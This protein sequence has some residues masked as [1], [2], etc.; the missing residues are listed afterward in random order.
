MN[1]IQVEAFSYLER[2]INKTDSKQGN[3]QIDIQYPYS[4]EEINQGKNPFWRYVYDDQGQAV[5]QQGKSKE[6]LS[7]T[8]S[9]IKDEEDYVY[10][11][12][13]SNP[14][15][16]DSSY[17]KKALPFLNKPNYKYFTK[18]SSLSEFEKF[19]S[20]QVNL[21]LAKYEYQCKTLTFPLKTQNGKTSIDHLAFNMSEDDE[22]T[23]VTITYTTS[24]EVETVKSDY[25]SLIKR[26][27]T[28]AYNYIFDQNDILQSLEYNYVFDYQENKKGTDIILNSNRDDKTYIYTFSY[29]ESVDCFTIGD[30]DK[31]Q[32]EKPNWYNPVLIN[33][34]EFFYASNN[35]SSG[36]DLTDIQDPYF[37]LDKDSY[38]LKIYKDKDYQQEVR[39]GEVISLTSPLYGKVEPKTGYAIIY[40]FYQFSFGHTYDEYASYYLE[41]DNPS[42]YDWDIKL[43]ATQENYTHHPLTFEGYDFQLKDIDQNKN[44]SSIN[45]EEGKTYIYHYE[46]E[47][48]FFDVAVKD[49]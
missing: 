44:I 10:R 39:Q 6:N 20:T 12:D 1:H 48:N 28:Y 27:N 29:P 19:A 42:M 49:R 35:L 33:D 25:T 31:S 14:T 32:I 40:S 41:D 38:E 17:Y 45:I 11:G 43:V 18:M 47:E 4:E 9:I 13:S 26:T 21:D 34:C 15:F 5:L 36:M 23:E 8:I 37:H 7:T 2:A 22:K 3:H 24:L 46:C 30:T 16:V